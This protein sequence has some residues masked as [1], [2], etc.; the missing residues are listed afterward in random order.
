MLAK[1]VKGRDFHGC[2]AYVLGKAGAIKIGGNVR[3][4][5]PLALSHEFLQPIHDRS[6]LTR[7][8]YHCAL[9]LPPGEILEDW[10]WRKITKD[11]LEAMGFK[12]SQYILVRHT[13]TDHHQHVHIVANRVGM[14]GKTVSESFDHFRCQTVVRAIEEAY[15]LQPV[16]SS[17]ESGR[18]ALS[19]RQLNKE[20]ETGK[21]S[22]QRIL[23]E[24]IADIVPVSLSLA[25]LVKRL[26]SHKI[27]SYGFYGRKGRLQGITYEFDGVTMSGT[28][29]GHN[30]QVGGLWTQLEKQ[31][32]SLEP[33]YSEQE[34][35]KVRRETIA[36]IQGAAFDQPKLSK[37]S[38]RLAEEEIDLH[39]QFAK[40]GRF[41]K[42]PKAIQ[43]RTGEICFH[44]SDLGSAYTLQGLQDKLGV[45]LDDAQQRSQVMEVRGVSQAIDDS[46]QDSVL[47]NLTQLLRQ[48][49]EEARQKQEKLEVYSNL[50][51]GLNH[52]LALATLY[53]KTEE[54]RPIALVIEPT[55]NATIPQAQAIREQ[56]DR[57]LQANTKNRPNAEKVWIDY[58]DEQNLDLEQ[59]ILWVKPQIASSSNAQN[60]QQLDR[61]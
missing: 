49:S 25:D 24:T 44:G 14:D 45:S 57:I 54:K 12:Y 22:V 20:A 5:D 23:Q 28:A 43:Y 32:A 36:A 59:R 40:V 37:L 60:L 7:L 27:K 13:D 46:L 48:L 38:D 58:G 42:R 52:L 29:L 18:K 10:T 16:T 55:D 21:P 30:Y 6:H 39:I 53:L 26:Q 11:Y 51:P 17:W 8:V 2:L 41:G 56:A 3:G 61:T 19:L 50:E 31:G 34:V 9:S 1:Q 33:W 4:R 35:E 47:E 15:N